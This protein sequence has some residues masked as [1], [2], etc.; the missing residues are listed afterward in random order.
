MHHCVETT[1]LCLINS[2]LQTTGQ[3]LSFITS[4]L[5]SRPPFPF[6]R[7]IIKLF[8]ADLGF[9][10]GLYTDQELDLDV[11]LSR[12]DKISFLVKVTSCVAIVTGERHD[13]FC[14]P[15]RILSGHD[16]PATHGFLRAMTRA[17]KAPLG[18]SKEAAEKVLQDGE[19]ALYR[20]G[21]KTRNAIVKLQ[22]LYRGT[23]SR[24][25]NKACSKA[26]SP[27]P[28]RG[29]TTDAVPISIDI[30]DDELSD[31]DDEHEVSRTTNVDKDEAMPTLSSPAPS[32][33]LPPIDSTQLPFLAESTMQ[34]DTI[35]P[36]IEAGVSTCGFTADPQEPTNPGGPK[37]PQEDD[38]P[39]PAPVTTSLPVAS[40]SE[41]YVGLD[42]KKKVAKKGKKT[43]TI[44]STTKT[45][46]VPKQSTTSSD[47]NDKR[48]PKEPQHQNLTTPKAQS[49]SKPAESS[50]VSN[51]K[52]K[53]TPRIIPKT[54]SCNRNTSDACTSVEL[55]CVEQ[56]KD[57]TEL[58]E[59]QLQH[60]EAV[61]R[62]TK[63]EASLKTRLHKAK[64]KE[65]ELTKKASELEER[66]ERVSR[67]ANNLRRQQH[68]LK[69]RE[70]AIVLKLDRH[71]GGQNAAAT[72]RL[73]QVSAIDNNSDTE[74]K[75]LRRKLFR[76]ER[77]VQ[78]RE[79]QI[80]VLVRRLRKALRALNSQRDASTAGTLAV[81]DREPA[82]R[83]TSVDTGTEVLDPKTS[84]KQPQTS[85]VKSKRA[86]KEKAK[87]TTTPTGT[88]SK[89]QTISDA[90]ENDCKPADRMEK[91]NES[92]CKDNGNSGSAQSGKKSV[93]FSSEVR[94]V[95]ERPQPMDTSTRSPK[96]DIRAKPLS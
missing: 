10:E 81:E 67:V 62:F 15:N 90:G 51:S 89:A 65:E 86:D 95:V 94:V 78:K 23:L 58:H 96:V 45:N 8:I 18:R 73:D 88:T 84:I 2:P 38:E 70:D 37:I 9:A 11:D 83:A 1:R 41:L 53:S 47:K 24:T 25:Q 56:A 71:H 5:L 68:L 13:V 42:G 40:P 69:Q 4:E 50:T 43:P 92:S 30:S 64:Q 36:D 31:K 85:V 54:R 26:E 35:K 77:R 63:A 61:E 87:P 34:E 46:D 19:T 80:R 82:E 72:S 79:E 32:G 16:V 93:S 57:V 33:R 75:G 66:E 12:K 28:A 59:K 49:K 27:A 6:L 91:K 74:I 17:C 22:A 29:D 60:K 52:K 3:D 20:R 44:T 7:V 76:S 55:D 21:V 48:K 14:A 39:E